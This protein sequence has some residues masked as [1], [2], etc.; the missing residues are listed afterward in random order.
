MPLYRYDE[1]D[2]RQ[3]MMQEVLLHAVSTPIV[4][5]LLELGYETDVVRHH[6]DVT[7]GHNAS[8]R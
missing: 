1:C 7:D 5:A 3:R 6:D 8:W 2:P 4:P